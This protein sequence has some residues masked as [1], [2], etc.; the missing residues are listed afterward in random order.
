[1][2][3]VRIYLLT[4]RKQPSRG[5]G[6]YGYRLEFVG[7]NGKLHEKE[8]FGEEEDITANQLALVAMYRALEELKKP[9][10]VEVFTDSLYLR[11]NFVANLQNWTLN[12]W[13]NAKGEPVA[14]G[15]LWRRLEEISARARD[16]SIS[17]APFLA[18][19]PN[20][21]IPTSLPS[22]VIAFVEHTN[23]SACA[24]L[25]WAFSGE[26]DFQCQ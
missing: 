5:K 21:S 17:E 13:L 19:S 8:V 26:S 7:K 12:S 16:A 15:G 24:A 1:M 22:R 2:D 20:E 23:Q 3:Q 9:C 25:S 14:N 6:Y 18:M 10:E 11:G 4:L